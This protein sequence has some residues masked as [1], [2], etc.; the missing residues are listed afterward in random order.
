MT[1]SRF[2]HSSRK[3]GTLKAIRRIRARRK[4]SLT[5]K[6]A[7]RQSP[8]AANPI[9]IA[10]MEHAIGLA[11]AAAMSGEIPVAAVVYRGEEI[12]AVGANNRESSCD[13]T[14]HAEMIALREAGRVLGS[15][16]LIGC[17]M[18]VTLEPCTMCAGALVNSRLD[19]LVYGAR[20]PKAGACSSLYH[21]PADSRLNHRVEMIGG[22]LEPRC[23]ELLRSF[24]RRRRA[25]KRRTA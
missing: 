24:F 8:T 15:W 22:V 1:P 9:D 4:R 25:E 10:M 11:N 20:D 17:S 12:I 13:P 5:K 19:R 6:L 7:K 2:S 3:T 21:I 23:G 18:A 14:G 16:R